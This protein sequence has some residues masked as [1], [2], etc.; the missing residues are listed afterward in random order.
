MK[1]NKIIKIF[2]FSIIAFASITFLTKEVSAYSWTLA[3]VT[4]VYVGNY[5][6]SSIKTNPL[7]V[8]LSCTTTYNPEK[9]QDETSCSTTSEPGYIITSFI[10]GDNSTVPVTLPEIQ[11]KEDGIQYDQYYNISPSGSGNAYPPVCT[12]GL[13]T[14]ITCVPGDNYIKDVCPHDTETQATPHY[15]Q[16]GRTFN[17]SFREYSPSVTVYGDDLIR[18][19]EKQTDEMTVPAP[20]SQGQK[21]AGIYWTSKDVTS[22][23]CTNKVEGDCGSGFSSFPGQSVGYAEYSLTSQ[24]KFTVECE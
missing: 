5:D 16:G 23:T 21:N 7:P 24:E 14:R 10:E 12:G 9:E 1:S 4:I 13:L 3:D 19:I 15:C 20:T 2:V 6:V 22:C 8:G 17:V 18:K 11:F